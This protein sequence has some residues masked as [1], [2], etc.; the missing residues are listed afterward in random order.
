MTE[1]S[2]SF[3]E[4]DIKAVVWGLRAEKAPGPNGFPVF[5]YMIFWDIIKADVIKLMECL[6]AGT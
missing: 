2:K 4:E 6:H 1:L 5:F 3:S